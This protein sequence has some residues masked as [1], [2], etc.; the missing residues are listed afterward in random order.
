MVTMATVTAAADKVTCDDAGSAKHVFTVSNV[1]GAPLRVGTKILVDEPA[2]SDWFIIE[3]E[4]ERDIDDQ[5]TD[6]VTVRAQIPE[7]TKPEQYTFQLL[8]F[9]VKEPGERF[10]EGPKVVVERSAISAPPPQERPP[11]PWWIVA[12]IVAVLIIGGGIAAWLMMGPEGVEVPDVVGLTT[13]EAKSE[14]KTSGLSVGS[15][16]K[17]KTDQQPPDIVI[18]QI[19][20]A[21]DRQEEGTPVNLI[22]AA[23]PKPIEV[24]EPDKDIIRPRI[25]PAPIVVKPLKITP[26]EDCISFNPKTTAASQVNNRWKIVDGS[27][28]MFD[29]AGNSGEAKK[30]L[31]IIKH[32]GMNKSCYVGRPNPSFKYMLVKNKAPRG[33]MGGEDCVSFNPSTATTKKVNNSWKIVD[34]SHLMFDFGNKQNEAKQSLQIIKYHGFTRS[35]FVGRPQPSFLYLRN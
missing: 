7:T 11:F 5:G 19:P 6:Q 21:G 35:C 18:D 32:Y 34:G 10:T 2:Q 23:K 12:V 30:S 8:V 4:S 15:I 25:P 3:G 17:E 24:T 31:S 29:F 26:K 20:D 9:S 28:W 13:D 27:H 16:T 22:V 14:I 33:A 1:S